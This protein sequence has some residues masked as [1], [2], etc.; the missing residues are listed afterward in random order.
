MSSRKPLIGISSTPKPE[1]HLEFVRFGYTTGVFRAG[2]L[3]LILPIS[4]DPAQTAHDLMSRIDGLVLSG[5]HDV[6][7]ALYGEEVEKIW[8]ELSP[9][10]DAHE[11]ALLEAALE[12]GKPVLAICRGMQLLNVLKGGSLIQ[13]IETEIMTDIKH[14]DMDL[15]GELM[16]PVD[17]EPGSRLADVIGST[18]L[19]VTTV[20]HQGVRI[21]APG[22]EVVARADDGMV[23]AIESPEYPNV[24]AVQWH[25]ELTVLKGDEP[26]RGLFTWLVRNASSA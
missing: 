5:G 16:H 26:S 7:P 25:P 14:L 11:L 21:V 10:R 1:D 12:L 24:V 2:G 22:F 23:E 9:E 4:P 18:R 8:G 6:D 3:P 13:D 17:L 19:D 20:H 15:K